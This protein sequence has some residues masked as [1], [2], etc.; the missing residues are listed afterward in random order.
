MSNKSYDVKKVDE[1]TSLGGEAPIP[2]R[3]M[4]MMLARPGHHAAV[5]QIVSEGKG[6]RTGTKSR[7]AV[8]L[9]I[10]TETNSKEA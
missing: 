2:R 9:K 10:S 7:R 4:G 8:R 1:R 6:K 3:R 5:I